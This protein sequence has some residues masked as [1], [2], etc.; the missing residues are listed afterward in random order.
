MLTRVL[1][2]AHIGPSDASLVHSA[3]TVEDSNFRNLLLSA[4]WFG[5]VDGG[6]F[7]YLPV[8]MARLG[9]SAS[10]VGLLTSAP[11]LLAMVAYIPGGAF[12]ER[13]RDQVKLVVR[14][15]TFSRLI[16][17]LIAA[18]PFFLAPSAIPI[19]TVILWSVLAIPSAVHIPAWM[20]VVQRAIPPRRRARLNGTR[21]AL[22]SLLAAVAMTFYGLLLDRTPFPAGY[23]IVFVASFLAGLLNMYYF[24][25]VKVAPFVAAPSPAAPDLPT[26]TRAK[27]FLHPFVE[28]PR[29]L[30]FGLANLV[31]RLVLTMPAGL[32]SVFWVNDLR[33]TDTWI[34]LRGTTGYA[35]LVV[36]YW[37]W[38]RV[39]NRIGHQRLL[40]ICGVCIAFYPVL[41]ALAPTMQWLLPAAA[42]WG[43]SL[44]G[45]E[46]GLFDIL[47]GVCRGGQHAHQHGARSRT[48]AGRSART[49]NGDAYGFA[50]YRHPASGRY[51]V[52]SRAT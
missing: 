52:L 12:A 51:S 3:E 50:G 1:R 21:W 22:M 7:N 33:A 26:I 34:G 29:F 39:A 14:V 31:Y 36:G 23:Q 9:A 2:R 16:Y 4:A 38:G 41:T 28:Y 15:A 35:A 27:A 5:P 25:K 48:V 44:S 47:L 6:I 37:F 10:V 11:S 17:L 49:G 45:I 46:L 32:F 24:G 40:L 43:F 13:R 42:V 20:S 19:A 18:L 8:F 30:R